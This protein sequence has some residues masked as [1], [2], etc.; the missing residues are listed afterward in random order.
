MDGAPEAP[1]IL[2]TS[3]CTCASTRPS[4]SL[5]I[6]VRPSQH[7]RPSP[8]WSSNPNLTD[9]DWENKMPATV[10]PPPLTGGV[11]RDSLSAAQEYKQ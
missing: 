6:K 10:G 3:A 5:Q 2:V 7:I 1:S 9:N 4:R 11:A 8:K